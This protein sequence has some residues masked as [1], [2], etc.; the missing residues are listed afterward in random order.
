MLAYAVFHA[1]GAVTDYLY[2]ATGQVDAVDEHGKQEY[3]DET[4]YSDVTFEDEGQIHSVTAAGNDER[5]LH[6][7]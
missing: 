4:G 7:R 6:E 5:V 3:Q 2:G 1:V